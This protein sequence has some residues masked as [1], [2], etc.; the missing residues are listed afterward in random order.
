[1]ALSARQDLLVR[2]LLAVTAKMGQ[3]SRD[4][5]SEGAGY[6]V[7]SAN[8]G[9]PQGFRCENCAFF[10]GPKACLVVKG[11]VDRGGICR[12]YVIPQD[13]LVRKPAESGSVGASPKT[14]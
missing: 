12:F 8:Y 2:A 4:A 3:F 10:R 14:R 13:R 7:A 6:V 5:G 11:I 1:M 9:A